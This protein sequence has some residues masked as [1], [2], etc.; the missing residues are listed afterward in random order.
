MAMGT[1]A[2]QAWRT[3]GAPQ[4][5]PELD[6]ATLW[7]WYSGTW[8]STPAMVAQQAS[9]PD[10]YLNTRQIWRQSSAIVNLYDQFVYM[11]DLS[12]NGEPLPDGSLGAIPLNP[13]AGTDAQNAALVKA[14]SECFSM[15]YWQQQMSL[16]PKMSAV[17]GDCLTELIPDFPH[18]RVTPLTY[19]PGYVADLQLDA[20]GHVK[21]YAVEYQVSQQRSTAY[22]QD[23]QAESYTYR[24]EVDSTGIW[25]YKDDKPFAYPGIGSTRIDNPFGFAPAT[26][27]RHESV[28]FKNRGISALEKTFRQTL[29]LNSLLSHASDYQR[30][31]FS[32]P[33][34]VVGSTSV[35]RGGRTINLPNGITVSFP[36]GS[37]PTPDEVE[38]A[39]SAAAQTMNVIGMTAE[40]K[41]VTIQFDIGSTVEMLNLAM[42]SILAETPEARYG[43]EVLKMGEITGPGME[44]ALGPIVGLVKQAR[45]QHDPQT[46]KRLQMA[47]SMM[48]YG[49]RSG[50]I[51]PEVQALR[52]SRYEAFQPFDLTSYDRGL[53]DCTVAGRDVFPETLLEKTQRLTLVQ[54]LTDPWLLTQ[55]GVPQAEVDRID[56][57]KQDQAD[58][59]AQML[60][61]LASA[62]NKGRT[63]PPRSATGP[64]GPS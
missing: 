52:P 58:A 20:L 15:W 4:W 7:T 57:E 11:G 18:G 37:D 42:D 47:T 41:F 5:G 2:M 33:V 9:D 8:T 49:L 56:Q 3:Y 39:R 1:A 26:W 10:L 64:T 40:G 36:R 53:M 35:P 62:D 45:K 12:T 61:G 29:E 54:A 28:P 59:E 23:L 31:Q 16:I 48:A 55:A 14:F 22:G 43:Q 32:A 13:Q 17:L 6:Y 21:A 19:W 51:P 50:A 38:A 25:Y 63:G 24:K 34:G 46:I 27:D 44:K 30:K 60:A